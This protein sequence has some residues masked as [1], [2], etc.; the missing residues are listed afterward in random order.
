MIAINKKPKLTKCS[1]HRTM[2]LIA[3]AAKIVATML[4]RRIEKKIEDVLG[5]QFGFRI[6]KGIRDAIE[7]LRIS[8]R[9]LE[10]GEELCACIID[11]QN[12]FDRVK[13]TKLMQILMETGIDWRDRRFI[14]RLYVDQSEKVRLDQGETSSVKTERGVTQGCCLS[15]ILFHLHSEYRSS[16]ALEW[17]R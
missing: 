1:D 5:D 13:Q 4:R 9:P 8:E 16:E 12:V 10:I 17:V 6:G 14:S 11:W 2:S 3:H 7:M 15:P